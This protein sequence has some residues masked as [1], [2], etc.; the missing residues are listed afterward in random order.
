MIRTIL[1]ICVVF[2]PTFIYSQPA[3]TNAGHPL[4]LSKSGKKTLTVHY[5][6][7]FETA[8]A[9]R[10][11]DNAGIALFNLYTLNPGDTVLQMDLLTYYYANKKYSEA[12]FLGERICKKDENNIAAFDIWTKSQEACGNFSN[13]VIN[14]EL[15]YLRTSNTYYKYLSAYCQFRLSRFIECEKYLAEVLTM[16][17]LTNHNVVMEISDGKTQEVPLK[18]AVLNLFGLVKA[19]LHNLPEATVYFK[20][21]LDVYPD[22]LLAQN[23]LKRALNQSN[24]E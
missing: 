5:K 12:M 6:N 13:A 21:A 9:L 24:K 15:L 11:M 18:A 22:F 10:D 23:N 19:E 20:K 1:V 2:L 4:P 7:A 17:D 3:Q 16:S 14:Y 8:K